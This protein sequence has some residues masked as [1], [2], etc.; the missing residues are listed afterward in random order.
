MLYYS[1]ITK[2]CTVPSKK[3]IKKIVVIFFFVVMAGHLFFTLRA[4]DAC[5]FCVLYTVHQHLKY[6]R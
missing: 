2:N 6:F 3:R 1:E 5:M 4:Y